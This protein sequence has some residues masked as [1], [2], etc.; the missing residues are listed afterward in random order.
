MISSQGGALEEGASILA[1]VKTISGRRIEERRKRHRITQKQLAADVGIGVRWL[2]EIEAGNPKSRVD[3]HIACAHALGL[4]S[5]HLIIPMLFLEHNMHFPRHFFL[6]DMQKLETLLVEF[7]SNLSLK[8]FLQPGNGHKG[9][10]G[11]G[12]AR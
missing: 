2:R 12:S 3:D 1:E 10:G 7:I 11:A 8:T 9:P 4:S 6:D 5:A